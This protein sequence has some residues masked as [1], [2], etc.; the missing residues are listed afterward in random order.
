MSYCVY[1]TTY[2]GE[3]MP[4][5][6]LG[7]TSSGRIAKGYR[8]SVRSRKWSDVWNRE[9]AEN[10]HLFT[11]EV[12]STH[13]TREEALAEELRLQ[14]EN[15]VVRSSEWINEAFAQP[16]GFAGRDV[17]GTANPMYGRGAAV[18][19]WC[20]NN[21]ELVSNRNRKSA[22][23]QWADESTR[24][25]K[26][27]GMRGVSKTRKTLSEE[28]FRELQRQK[29]AIS[30]GKRAHRIEYNGVVYVGWRKFTEA[31]GISKYAYK[32]QMKDLSKS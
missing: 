32:K 27:E 21:P 20:R 31:T 16:K 14:K 1:M 30:N 15:D 3:L 6:Y 4:T 29:S 10:P 8:G 24:N 9:L 28:E 26:V 13:G 5:Y 18:T 12:L 22:V 11:T 23:T 17:S 25:K 19:E 7:S 2:S